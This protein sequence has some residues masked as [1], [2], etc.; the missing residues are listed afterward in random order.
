MGKDSAKV[1]QSKALKEKWITKDKDVFKANVA[2][3]LPENCIQTADASDRWIRLSI[4][5]ASK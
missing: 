1:G 4:H 3:I 2:A 5:L